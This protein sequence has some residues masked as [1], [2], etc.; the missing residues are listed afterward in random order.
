MHGPY[1]VHI[2]VRGEN[3]PLVLT[4]TDAELLAGG[5]V[6]ERFYQD[7][8]TGLA[9][10][11]LRAGVFAAA[12]LLAAGEEASV[13]VWG[14]EGTEGTSKPCLASARGGDHS[15]CSRCGGTG[16]L[17]ARDAQWKSASARRDGH[18]QFVTSLGSRFNERTFR[19]V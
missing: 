14:R 5:R 9:E 4:D 18:G 16:R 15:Y 19:G 11:A 2:T 17:T 7:A 12:L 6:A 3:T 13:T 1:L 10:G 8:S